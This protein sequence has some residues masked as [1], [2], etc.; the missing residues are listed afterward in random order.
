MKPCRPSKV[1]CNTEE[2]P[3]HELEEIKIEPHHYQHNQENVSNDNDTEV[4]DMETHTTQ[5][6]Y[7]DEFVEETALEGCPVNVLEKAN[8]SADQCDNIDLQSQLEQGAVGSTEDML[9]VRCCDVNEVKQS[10]TSPLVSGITITDDSDKNS[11][12]D[13]DGTFSCDACVCMISGKTGSSWYRCTECG[14]ADFCDL[15]YLKDV[16]SQ[17]RTHM[18][19]F[20]CPADWNLIYCDSCGL[21]YSEDSS[22]NLIHQCTECE[23]YCLCNGC[24]TK[25]MHIKHSNS[26]QTNTIGQYRTAIR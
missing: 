5:T 14:D 17:H 6:I 4:I 9:R 19:K 7:C 3:P 1:T 8:A 20:T 18:N 10:N 23:D 16:H 12:S 11:D 24:R 15:C 2:L 25:M 22:Y 21:S 13:D 26:F